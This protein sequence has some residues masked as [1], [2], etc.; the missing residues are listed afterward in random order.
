MGSGRTEKTNDHQLAS[1]IKEICRER[2]ITIHPQNQAKTAPTES[3]KRYGS[4]KSWTLETSL[5]HSTKS[6]T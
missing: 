2:G 6:A 4:T 5:L 3:R 1:K